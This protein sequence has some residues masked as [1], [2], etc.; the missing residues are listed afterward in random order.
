VKDQN[1][2]NLYT[3]EWQDSVHYFSQFFSMKL[4][5][6]HVTYLFVPSYLS[7]HSISSVDDR[8]NPNSLQNVTSV[9]GLLQS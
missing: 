4:L 8:A 6:M 5:S 2:S 7:I 1:G 9:S 3:A